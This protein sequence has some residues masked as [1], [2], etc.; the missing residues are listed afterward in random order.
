MRTGIFSKG[1]DSLFHSQARLLRLLP[2][3]ALLL[4]AALADAQPVNDA[5]VN[6]IPITLGSSTS[7]TTVG[8]TSDNV[9]A[10]GVSAGRGTWYSFSGVTGV[11]VLNICDASFSS[12]LSVYSGSCGALQCVFGRAP[13]CTGSEVAI[14]A[15]PSLTYYVLVN[16]NQNTTGSFSLSLQLAADQQVAA[17]DACANAIPLHCG[18]VV[19]GSTA[20]ALG[21]YAPN[22][23]VFID[24]PGVWYTFHHVEGDMS[25]STCTQADYDTKIQLYY[26]SCGNLTCVYGS[27]DDCSSGSGSLI[28]FWADPTLTYYLLVD[29]SGWQTGTF[30]LTFE[31]IWDNECH[32]DIKAFLGGP[33]DPATGLMHDSLRTS[34]SFPLTEPYT[35]LG[36]QHVGGGGEVIA[37]SVLSTSGQDAVVDWVVLELR[38]RMTPGTRVATRSA[39]LQR[40]GDVVDLDG[41]SNPAFSV[42]E[43]RYH[44]AIR[45]R[46]HLGVMTMASMQDDA[47]VVD[48]SDPDVTVFG[49]DAAR[50]AIDSTMVLWPGYLHGHPVLDR[51]VRQVG[52]AGLLQ[53]MCLRP[54]KASSLA[55]FGV[56]VAAGPRAAPR[57]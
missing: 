7:G 5:C 37:P 54:W 11:I 47:M 35:A 52:H 38:A 55:R 30:T 31:S 41:F 22:C 12:R 20:H 1:S 2:L 40:D 15:D 17:N 43:G 10:C 46:N 3:V 51:R 9:P 56:P 36:Y 23:A 45:H 44:L 33:Y 34:G 4:V 49:R 50:K 14:Q 39:L 27:D 21:D 57:R 19:Q 13:S 53:R 8:A 16:G 48:F 32:T 18:S 26:G 6:A 25:L 28:N 42:A 24:A 29:G